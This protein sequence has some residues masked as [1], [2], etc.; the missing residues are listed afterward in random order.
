M[1]A[2]A[3]NGALPVKKE[4]DDIEVTDSNYE[5]DSEQTE[6]E[7]VI[8]FAF[9]DIKL[10]S[11]HEEENPT[12]SKV[13]RG[14]LGVIETKEE[15]ISYEMKQEIDEN[16]SSMLYLNE[17]S[18]ENYHF[19]KCETLEINEPFSAQ[20]FSNSNEESTVS[21][22]EKS[23]LKNFSKT[24]DT[25]TYIEKKSFQCKVCSKSFGRAGSL[26]S[27]VK[28]HSKEKPFQ[29]KICAKTFIRNDYLKVHEKIHS[30][31]NRFHCKMCSKSFCRKENLKLHERSHTGEKPFQCKI[32]SKS[33]T[34][35]NSLKLH[36]RTHTGEKAFQCK[37]CSK[38]FYRCAYLKL[39]EE[40]HTGMKS[41][42]CKICSKSFLRKDNLKYHE[43][44]HT[45][46]KLFQCGT[47]SKSFTRG[48]SLRRH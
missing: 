39:H 37:I 5:F 10:E 45:G 48:S 36:E 27:H 24:T 34:H 7:N 31:K 32:C 44:T 22:E 20:Y 3:E 19:V 26:K 1:M 4:Y 47:C 15:K 33:Y 46:E 17:S 11:W 28:L 18:V 21:N 38:A 40:T 2:A 14:D 42:H 41:F 12:E 9:H 6:Q 35:R 25:E 13:V 8:D 29:C 16:T 23:C 43:K 30:E